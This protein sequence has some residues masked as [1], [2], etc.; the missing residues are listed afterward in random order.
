MPPRHL[1]DYYVNSL[2]EIREPKT[3]QTA[4]SHPAW[5]SAMQSE[6]DAIHTNQT[7][8]LV[9]PPPHANIISCKWVFKVKTGLPDST[10]KFKARLVARGDE[11]FDGLD[12]DEVFSPVARWTTVRTIAALAAQANWP[13]LHLDVKTAFLNGD[14]PSDQPVFMKQPRGFVNAT[15]PHHVCKLSKALY[16]LRQAPRLWNSKFDMF[17]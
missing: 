11:Q 12:Y 5:V 10:P 15:F 17:L 4:A 7:W 9:A 2:S 6:I 3:F 13:I 16:G 14:L 1:T 8:T